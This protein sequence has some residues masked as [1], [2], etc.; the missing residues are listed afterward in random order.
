MNF[1]LHEGEKGGKYSTGH[2]HLSNH[3]VRTRA[4]P[5]GREHV[6]VFGEMPDEFFPP[7]QTP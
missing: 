3:R 4:S 1:T 5:R 6:G 2:I 7:P